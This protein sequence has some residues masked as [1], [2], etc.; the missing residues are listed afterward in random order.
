MESTVVTKYKQKE[1][2][3]ISWWKFKFWSPSYTCYWSL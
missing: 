1:R 3:I 2:E